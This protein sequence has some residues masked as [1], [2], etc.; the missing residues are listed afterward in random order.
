MSKHLSQHHTWGRTAGCGQGSVGLP[1]LGWA[2][3]G[4]VWPCLAISHSIRGGSGLQ[5]WWGSVSLPPPGWAM[6]GHVWPYLTAPQVG[7]DRRKRP[8][9]CAHKDIGLCGTL[10]VCGYGRGAG[11]Q[12]VDTGEELAVSLWIRERSWLSVC[13]YRRGA[14]CQSVDTGEELAV[15]LWIQERSWLSVCGYR[16][17]AGC[18]SVD[19]G[20]E[21]AVSLWIR[22]RSWLSVCGYGRGAGCQ[23]V[24][25]GEEL[26][27]SLW[28]Q[29]RSWLCPVVSPKMTCA[30]LSGW[31]TPFSS[32]PTR[33]PCGHSVLCCFSECSSDAIS[34]PC[35]CRHITAG[36]SSDQIV[37]R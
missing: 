29:E 9:V 2:M 13:G 11:C 34:T 36:V 3:S 20:E 7:Q 21:L 24:D 18:Q 19:T 23:S 15:S 33:R 28:I 26:A 37:L 5:M 12:S 35:M 32:V 17:G 4:H 27:V 31:R 30:G 8:G 6:S 10:S 16:R 1:P 25:T 14:G 22:E